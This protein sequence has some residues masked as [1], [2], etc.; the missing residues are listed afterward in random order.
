MVNG[1]EIR[2]LQSTEWS[3]PITIKYGKYNLYNQ[4]I[5]YTILNHFISFDSWIQN[6]WGMLSFLNY[7]QIHLVKFI[8]IEIKFIAEVQKVVL[9]FWRCSYIFDSQLASNNHSC[10]ES[11]F[12][13]INDS[14]KD[15]FSS[16]LSCFLVIMFLQIDDYCSS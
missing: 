16:I 4:I 7:Y 10:S 13:A 8:K 5:V 3:A 6:K 12:D 9:N 15:V 1:A 11:W 14:Q 2:I